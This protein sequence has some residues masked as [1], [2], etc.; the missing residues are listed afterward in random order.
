MQIGSRVRW[1]DTRGQLKHGTVK[2]INLLTD[3]RCM[4][5]LI[6][7]GPHFGFLRLDIPGRCHSS[8]GWSAT[9]SNA[10]VSLTQR[11]AF[12]TSST[13]DYNHRIDHVQ[14]AG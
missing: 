13:Q 8:G 11:F 14:L 9:I 12:L 2:Q 6:P 3:V 4:T 7:P 10:S 5:D 1:W